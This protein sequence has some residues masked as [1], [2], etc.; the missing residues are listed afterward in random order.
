MKKK[1]ALLPIVTLLL[2][3]VLALILGRK[4]GKLRE[5]PETVL[6]AAGA[7]RGIHSALKC[8][9]AGILITGAEL[10]AAIFINSLIHMRLKKKYM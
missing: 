10:L 7:V 1:N 6:R 5:L 2:P 9:L 3:A 8:V 4:G